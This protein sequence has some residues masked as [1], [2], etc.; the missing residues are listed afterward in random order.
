MIRMETLEKIQHYTI[1]G[2]SFSFNSIKN[3]DEF[4]HYQLWC[5]NIKGPRIGR[6]KKLFNNYIFGL[7]IIKITDKN[8]IQYLFRKQILRK[9]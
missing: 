6:D 9:I 4:N 8:R 3:T 5:L 2:Y 7:K 1:L